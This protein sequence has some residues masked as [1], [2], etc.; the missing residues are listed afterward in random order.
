MPETTEGAASLGL[1]VHG[2]KYSIAAKAVREVIHT[3]AITRVPYSPAALVGVANLRGAVLPVVS[4]AS[5]LG[6]APSAP[7]LRQK[8]VVHVGDEAVGILVDAVSKL[9]VAQVSE[10]RLDIA[11]LLRSVIAEK[12]VPRASGYSPIVGGAKT[13][14]KIVEP[15]V[16][17]FAFTVSEQRFALPLGSVERVMAFP[18]ELSQVTGSNGSVMGMIN[19]GDSVLPVVTLSA[20]LGLKANAASSTQ[21]IVVVAFEE[22]KVGLLVDTVDGVRR[23][24]E[25]R[26]DM[27]PPLLRHGGGSAEIEAIGRLDDRTLVSV[28]SVEKLFGNRMI[29]ESVAGPQTGDG[30]VDSLNVAEAGRFLVFQLGDEL[31]G[32]PIAAVDEVVAVPTQTTRLPNAPAFV[33]GVFNLRG[34]AVPLINQRQRFETPGVPAGDRPR[35]IVATVGALQAG[36]I[37]DA[38]SEVMPI[39]LHAIAPTPMMSSEGVRVFSGVAQLSDGRTVLLVDAQELLDRAERDMLAAL[40]ASKVDELS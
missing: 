29:S 37:V 38:V 13:E 20:L 2:K 36:F 27:V 1:T 6:E 30:A 16:A 14:Q 5:L 40:S 4:L 33:S 15:H 7:A 39:A 12:I 10:R 26:I 17:L 32:L 11:E 8:I 34:K 25:S 22:T 9:G 18:E 28:L 19:L 21:R 35:V 3:P 24:P 31:Y 23:M